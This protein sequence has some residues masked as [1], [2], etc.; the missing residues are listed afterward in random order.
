MNLTILNRA[1]PTKPKNVTV[2]SQTTMQD[3]IDQHLKDVSL[4]NLTLFVGLKF[5]H[6][7][8]GMKVEGG[9]EE[10]GEDA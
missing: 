1:D 4:E 7:I 8:V 2:S 3:L 9:V 6:Q 5:S 10:A